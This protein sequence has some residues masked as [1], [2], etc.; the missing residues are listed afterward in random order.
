[1][2]EHQTPRVAGKSG[3]LNQTTVFGEIIPVGYSEVLTKTLITDI[4]S[5]RNYM[6]GSMWFRYTGS[7]TI[8]KMSLFSPVISYTPTCIIPK[9]HIQDKLLILEREK[10]KHFKAPCFWR[11]AS[12]ITG[13]GWVVSWEDLQPFGK[14]SCDMDWFCGSRRGQKGGIEPQFLMKLAFNSKKISNQ[15]LKILASRIS[16]CY[17]HEMKCISE[18]H[19]TK[20]LGDREQ[21]E[22]L[23]I[24][25]EYKSKC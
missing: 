7:S 21:R 9:P 23:I 5:Q 15:W 14:P 16:V 3:W 18:T 25:V 6:V 22:R 13:H 10:R 2:T 8:T 11:G 20:S 24:S 17:L 12:G 19:Q 4:I 1:M